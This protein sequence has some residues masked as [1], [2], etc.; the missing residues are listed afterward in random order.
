MQVHMYMPEL[1][2]RAFGLVRVLLK[3]GN[4][5]NFGR[6]SDVWLDSDN[7]VGSRSNLPNRGDAV[8][9]IDREW[10]MLTLTTHPDRSSGYSLYIDGLLKGDLR[11]GDIRGLTANIS[12]L[13][14]HVSGRGGGRGQRQGYV[15]G[16]PALMCS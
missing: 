2:L 3:D 10:H 13:D 9:I 15:A 6:R 11:D 16:R 14:I 12:D 8:D 4:D 7:A 5:Y 1:G